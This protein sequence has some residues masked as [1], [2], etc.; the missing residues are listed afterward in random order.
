M[1]FD[2][3]TDSWAPGEPPVGDASVLAPDP[4]K[5]TGA[6]SSGA[7]SFLKDVGIDP[8]RNAKVT[9]E[10]AGIA[11]GRLEAN[12]YIDRQNMARLEQDRARMDKAFAMES[13]A[14][15]DPAL[16]HPWNADQERV[17][18][19][20]GP[21][22]TFGSVGMVFALAASAFTRTPLTSA[23][24]AGAAAMN[25]IHQSDEK[26]Y[27]SAYEA[28]KANSDLAI[29]R[30]NMERNLYEDANKLATTDVGLWQ[31]KRAAI[32]AQFDDRKAIT[33]LE[34]GMAPE[35]LQLDSQRVEMANKLVQAQKGFEDFNRDRELY[36]E[37]VRSHLQE[38]MTPAQQLQVKLNALQ[39]VQEARRP[40]L[41]TTNADATFIQQFYAE[42]PNATPEEFSVAFGEFK[43]GQKQPGGAAGG[44]K[45]GSVN[46]D[47]VKMDSEIRQEHPDWT[48]AQVIEERNKRLKASNTSDAG[49]T[50]SKLDAREID[51]RAK[52][53]EADGMDKTAA[54]D[55]AKTEVQNKPTLSEDEAAFMAEQYMQGDKSVLQ[56][57]GR[58]VQ[59]QANLIY[60]RKKVV[61]LAK[62]EGVSP[63]ELATRMAEFSGM[64]AAQRTLGTRTANVEMFNNEAINMMQ[65]AQQ[66][67]HEFSRTQF[68]LINKALIAYEKGSG[69]PKVRAFGAAI[70]EVVNTYAKA[71]NGGNAGTVH[72]K[73]NAREL[74]KDIDTQEQF[75]AVLDIMRKG[76]EQ[77]RR[78]PGQVRQELR[79]LSGGGS[80]LEP[81][82]IPEPPQNVIRYDA[83]GNRV[84]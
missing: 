37:Y 4:D 34:N 70:N 42:H 59:G 71:I 27:E 17:A 39:A 1:A 61:E 57:L 77:A 14:A 81:A 50:V 74:L 29:K 78:A 25:A 48:D 68:P 35:L 33:M 38:G 10:L 62:R 22:E 11:K 23:L 47:R 84:Q 69:D 13:A 67:S 31:A 26:A 12:T 19:A 66:A 60:L 7:S 58:G 54:Y 55:Q 82:K 36:T 44:V 76:L 9:S 51:R 18:R 79:T 15:D 20:H 83:Q 32:A 53:Y 8:E 56:N 24:N 46:E 64:M 3:T 43:R 6:T 21:L 5:P 40:P 72:D 80:T 2:P 45:P 41:R 28:W 30:F 63:Q 73:E 49:M 65:I 52:I 16:R 75:D